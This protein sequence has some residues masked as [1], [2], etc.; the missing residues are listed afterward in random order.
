[1]AAR[2]HNG[3]PCATRGC[4]RRVVVAAVDNDGVG[5]TCETCQLPVLPLQRVS[6]PGEHLDADLLTGDRCSSCQ[7]TIFQRRTSDRTASR[8]HSIRPER[9]AS[10][11]RRAAVRRTFREVS[12]GTYGRFVLREPRPPQHEDQL[13]PSPAPSTRI[14]KAVNTCGPVPVRPSPPRPPKQSAHRLSSRRGAPPGPRR[15]RPQ[16]RRGRRSSPFGEMTG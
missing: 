15:M 13:G 14:R 3:P 5:A 7:A 4:R 12:V 10:D 16:A 1:M 6:R 8:T 9:R 2:Q 11:R